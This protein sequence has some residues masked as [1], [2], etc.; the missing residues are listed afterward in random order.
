MVSLLAS[1]NSSM[2]LVTMV[3]ILKNIAKFK[4]EIS[5]HNIWT[6]QSKTFQ[7]SAMITGFYW[8]THRYLSSNQRVF[9]TIKHSQ[10]YK[11]LKMLPRKKYPVYT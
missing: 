2:H 3:A 10:F 5:P 7:L 9:L 1:K 6:Y 11:T 4:F 8:W